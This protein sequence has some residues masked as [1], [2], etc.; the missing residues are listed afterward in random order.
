MQIETALPD[1]RRSLRP[2]QCRW[3]QCRWRLNEHRH[4][5]NDDAEHGRIHRHAQ[6]DPGRGHRLRG[7][8]RPRQDRLD[9]QG[10]RGDRRRPQDGRPRARARVRPQR[11]ARRPQGRRRGRG[12]PGAHRE[13]ARRGRPVARQ[14]QA[15]GELDPSRASVRGWREGSGRHLQQGQ[16]WL[17]GR[18]RRRRGVPAGQPGRYPP[19]SRHRPANASVAAVPDPQDGPPPRQHRGVA[20]FRPGRDACRAARRY[21]G[22]PGRGPGDR[23]RGQEHHRLRRVH[24]PRRYRRPAARDR[25]G[26]APRQ[27][28]Q[29]DRQ[30]R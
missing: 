27:P 29:R 6:R 30:R 11:Q 28:P 9:R 19:G 2:R 25:H 8:C 7:Q 3:H 14:G 26:L 23:G 24:R 21:R 18:S 22:S 15:R 1:G 10:L 20:P 16:G 4:A 5:Q 17:H 12:L 13:C